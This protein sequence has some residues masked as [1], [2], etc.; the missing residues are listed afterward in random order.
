MLVRAFPWEPSAEASCTPLKALKTHLGYVYMIFFFLG[1]TIPGQL[2]GGK[3]ASA[4]D[5]WQF[6][7][8]GVDVLLL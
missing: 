6:R 5:W 3:A 7:S 2:V 1:R 8:M 4:G